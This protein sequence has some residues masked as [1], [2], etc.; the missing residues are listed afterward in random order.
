MFTISHNADYTVK[1]GAAAAIVVII[2]SRRQRRERRLWAK[3]RFRRR[4]RS[5]VSLMHELALEEPLDFLNY[6]RISVSTFH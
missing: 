1:R 5:H 2:T 4:H 6:L 3:L